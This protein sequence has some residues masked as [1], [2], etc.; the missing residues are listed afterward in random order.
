MPSTPVAPPAQSLLALSTS[1]ALGSHLSSLNGPEPTA[2]VPIEPALISLAGTMAALTSLIAVRIGTSGCDRWNTTVAASGV[3]MLAIDR[4]LARAAAPVFSSRM[5]SNEA[6][7]SAEV[8]AVPS[9]NFALGSS[10]KVSSLPSVGEFPG[11]GDGGD[12]LQA[13]VDPHQR[14]IDQLQQPQRRKRRLLVRVEP[15]G[16]LR[17]GHVQRRRLR[18]NRRDAEH[19]R[20]RDARQQCSCE[21]PYHFRLPL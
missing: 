16:V 7:T 6:L 8:T 21:V 10:L 4:K 9:W 19:R 13:G 12:D 14:L 15:G 20:Q 1:L 3:S 17:P 5:R 18:R 11:R 2:L